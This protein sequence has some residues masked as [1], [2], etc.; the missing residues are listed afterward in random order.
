MRKIFHL[1]VGD[2]DFTPTDKQLEELVA[3][4]HRE[5]V[6]VNGTHVEATSFNIPDGEGAQRYQLI[7]TAGGPDWKPIQE[8]L[9]AIR[10]MFQAACVDPKGGVVATRPEV[11]VKVHLIGDDENG[12]LVVSAN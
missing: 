4:F 7:V 10:D 5:G 6:F 8:E 3:R 12:S 2:S 1:R 11:E 9:D